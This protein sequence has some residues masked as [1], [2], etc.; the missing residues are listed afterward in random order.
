HG[1]DAD[2]EGR[3]RW[4]GAD[5]N[6]RPCGCAPGGTRPRHRRFTK[7]TLDTIQWPAGCKLAAHCSAAPARSNV[8][9]APERSALPKTRRLRG[10]EIGAMRWLSVIGYQLSIIRFL[11]RKSGPINQ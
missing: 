10:A 2:R 6:P 4:T 7:I 1:G 8:R 11:P 9:S 3:A 5:R